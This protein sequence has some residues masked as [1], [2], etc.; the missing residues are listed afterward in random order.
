MRSPQIPTQIRLHDDAFRQT[1]IWVHM[2]SARRQLR[3][4]C[5]PENEFKPN[6]KLKLKNADLSLRFQYHLHAGF[7]RGW[8]EGDWGV[9]QGDN[10]LENQTCSFVLNSCAQSQNWAG[11]F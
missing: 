8:I 6:L 7:L 10:W 9:D 1:D 3:P 5:N 2:R 11:D 4:H